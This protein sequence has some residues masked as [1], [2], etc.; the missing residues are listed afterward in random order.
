MHFEPPVRKR[1]KP[2]LTPLID[3]VFLLLIFFLLTL[4]II[5]PEGE[6]NINMPIGTPTGACT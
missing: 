3:V 6:F 2:S 4:K 5:E 1:R